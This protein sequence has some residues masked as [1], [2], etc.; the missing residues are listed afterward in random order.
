MLVILGNKDSLCG[1]ETIERYYI[2][3]IVGAMR[4]VSLPFSAPLEVI[5]RTVSP[6]TVQNAL[7][8]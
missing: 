3:V 6:L 4:A 5:R 2:L 8:S 1:V 7:K